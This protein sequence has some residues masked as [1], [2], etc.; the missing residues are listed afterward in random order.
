MYAC[1]RMFTSLVR[2]PICLIVLLLLVHW[3]AKPMG[4]S[5][6]KC[7]ITCYLSV[8]TFQMEHMETMHTHLLPA[9]KPHPYPLLPLPTLTPWIH[10]HLV[11]VTGSVQMST[12]NCFVFVP[13][14]ELRTHDPI[15]CYWN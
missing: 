3:P 9:T 11:T 7:Q 15:L 1:A 4:L 10:L 13:A 2:P 5:Y 14:N 6:H 8:D 12:V